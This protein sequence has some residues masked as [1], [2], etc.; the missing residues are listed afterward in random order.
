MS[1]LIT[2][3][4]V[5]AQ[6]AGFADLGT[7]TQSALVTAASESVEAY[8]RRTFAAGT[9][10]EYVDG[11]GTPRLWLSRRPVASVS[12]LTIDGGTLDN[13]SGDAWVLD[14]ARG[15][16][17]RGNGTGDPRHAL[18]W[19][20]GR[21]NVVVTYVGGYS[22]IPGPVKQAAI[23]MVKHMSELAAKTGLLS[24]ESLGGYSYVLNT[25]FNKGDVPP[26]IGMM[27]APYVQD[28]IA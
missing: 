15:E 24:S 27:L 5:T 25:A 28:D 14:G 20:R 21:R 1:D 2:T 4:E 7:A 8:C 18:G 17:T 19:P 9:V 22:S 3:A 12:T 11:R 6:W 26:G 13:T 16:L 23:A 10:T